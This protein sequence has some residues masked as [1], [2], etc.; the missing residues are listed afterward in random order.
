MA[1]LVGRKLVGTL[2]LLLGACGGSVNLHTGAGGAGAG[3]SPVVAGAS[4]YG[5]AGAPT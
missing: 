5:G 3:G 1:L 2:T 4:G